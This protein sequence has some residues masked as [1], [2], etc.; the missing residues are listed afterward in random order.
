MASAAFSM[1]KTYHPTVNGPETMTG[2][3]RGAKTLDL[4]LKR[5]WRRRN[6]PVKA[7]FL[8]C[9]RPRMALKGRLAALASQGHSRG[10]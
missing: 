6:N 9:E 2:P 1:P 4:G 3:G 5:L 10:L 7:Q 8:A